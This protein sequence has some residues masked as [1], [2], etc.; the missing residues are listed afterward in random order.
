MSTR[1]SYELDYAL[2]CLHSAKDDLAAYG[3]SNVSDYERQIH[4]LNKAASN[5]L[6][7]VYTLVSIAQED[8]A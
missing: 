1:E 5:L 7:A 2:A 6:Q 8:K 4:L 3:Q